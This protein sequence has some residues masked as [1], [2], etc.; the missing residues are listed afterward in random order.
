VDGI[1]GPKDVEM[2]KESL[3]SDGLKVAG[4]MRLGVADVLTCNSFL[5]VQPLTFD[6]MSLHVLISTS[7]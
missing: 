7:A 1:I 4:K 5:K 2:D 3:G 6:V